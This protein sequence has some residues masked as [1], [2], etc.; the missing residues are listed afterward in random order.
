VLSPPLNACSTS[1]AQTSC[2]DASFGNGGLV[3]TS[4]NTQDIGHM[5][6]Q[7]TDGKL[8][9]IGQFTDHSGS[10]TLG[11]VILER[12]NS[13]G[14]L[15]TAFASSRV[16]RLYISGTSITQVDDGLIDLAGNIL[17]IGFNG[18]NTFVARFTPSGSPDT[19]FGSGGLSPFTG[20]G[21]PF[22]LAIQPDGKIVLSTKSSTKSGTPV[23]YVLRMNPNGGLDTTFGTKGAA[24]FSGVFFTDVALQQINAATSILAT[25]SDFSIVRYT[26]AGAL[27]TSFGTSGV[28][29]NALCGSG[30]EAWDIAVDPVSGIYVAGYAL[31]QANGPRKIYLAKYTN[32]GQLDPTFGDAANYGQGPTGATI[33]DFNGTGSNGNAGLEVTSDSL[34]NRQILVGVTIPTN[35][36]YLARYKANGAL[37]TNW[38]GVG[39]VGTTFNVASG[40]KAA[41]SSVAVQGDGRI[42]QVGTD[43]GPTA[44]P[45]PIN[46]A[47]ARF[48]Q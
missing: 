45:T 39:A 7:Q 27:D 16:E 37:D 44:S 5:V 10:T 48:W 3:E 32:S 14:S 36:F 43:Q 30:G 38:G 15:A 23:G 19:T 31:L 8:V 35:A 24:Q 22:G 46:I 20:Y 41:P 11:G 29:K 33:L 6:R 13:D 25:T 42:L 34:G 40:W 9:V 18:G 17:A 1:T 4:T 26:P 47:L 21:A 2:L 12:Y 28:A